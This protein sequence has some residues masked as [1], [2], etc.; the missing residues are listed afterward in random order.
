MGVLGE[1]WEREEEVDEEEK[2]DEE[3]MDEGDGGIEE[4]VESNMTLPTLDCNAYS[5]KSGVGVSLLSVE[6]FLAASLTISPPSP[7]NTL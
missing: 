6:M 2:N 3:E 7:D 1:L 4:D 5:K